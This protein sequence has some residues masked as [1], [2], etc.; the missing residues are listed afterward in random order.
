MTGKGSNSTGT[1]DANW[2]RHLDNNRYHFKR[3]KPE[4]QIQFAFQNHWRV[5]RS[6]LGDINSGRVLEVGC[7]RGS[8]AAFFAAEGLNVH[9]LDIS[10]T[11]LR[12]ARMNFTVDDLTGFY[13]CGD[14]LA[15]PY[16]SGVFD[17]V[18]SI[19][20]FEHFAEIHQPLCEQVRILKPG[21]VFLGYIVPQ[22]NLSVQTLVLPINIALRLGYRIYGGLT[23][24][25]RGLEN[26]KKVPLYR[27]NYK[28]KDYLSALYA[29]GV[30]KAGSFGM[31]PLPL[32][33]H[34]PNF[35]F[36]LM[37][38]FLER[39]LVW[40]WQLLLTARSWRRG[41]PWTCTE[42]WG[43]AF[44]VWARKGRYNSAKGL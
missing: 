21:G 34:S 25:S 33:S 16:P 40:L 9:L 35:P 22:K 29:L 30:E 24:N 5:F 39:G 31:F 15:L 10:E 12:M 27:N 14:A 36:S 19:G 1:F 17:V 38:P 28:S 2:R 41:D 7:G 11:A 13:V 37:A 23:F 8:M 26:A 3:G 4:N 43:L 20:L 42:H 18:L 32:I 44:L 6:L